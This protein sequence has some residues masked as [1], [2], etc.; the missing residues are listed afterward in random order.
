MS[1]DDILICSRCTAPQ[2]DTCCA[3]CG[4]IEFEPAAY[5]SSMTPYTIQTF[6]G[7]LIDLRHV[8]PDDISIRD[9][10]HSL[11]CINRFNGHTLVPLSVAQHSVRVSQIVSKEHSLWGLLHDASEAYL[12]DV[13]RPLKHLLP[14]YRKMETLVQFAIARHFG[15]TVPMPHD[16]KLADQSVLMAEKRD[17]MMIDRDWGF[18]VPVDQQLVEPVIP[19]QATIMFMDR[20]KELT[21]RGD[22]E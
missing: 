16:V 1:S 9:I 10:A 11:G 13:S 12:G 18:R 21:G 14:E 7:R 19:S 8:C 20:F 17:L 2:T 4:G 5:R 22:A 15:L 6:T 3:E